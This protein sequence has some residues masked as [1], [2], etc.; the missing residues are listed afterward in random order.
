M[1]G[2][3]TIFVIACRVYKDSS[4]LA[5][6]NRAMTVRRIPGVEIASCA[7]FVTIS[8]LY[9]AV[10]I[11]IGLVV[12]VDSVDRSSIGLKITFLNIKLLFCLGRTPFQTFWY[13]FVAI[14]RAWRI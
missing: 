6:M 3:S 2:K 1:T 14:N 7:K 13:G 5:Y 10:V 4:D 9:V 12:M 11:C 8:N